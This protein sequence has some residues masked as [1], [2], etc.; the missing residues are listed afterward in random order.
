[1]TTKIKKYEDVKQI[2]SPS[3]IKSTGTLEYFP[4]FMQHIEL[5]CC[6]SF[7]LLE[8]I[9]YHKS[10]IVTLSKSNFHEFK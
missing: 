7:N 9:V 3:S 6:L 1:M 4:I 8:I 5:Y 10:F 2:I